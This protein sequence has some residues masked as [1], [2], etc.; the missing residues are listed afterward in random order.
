M[1]AVRYKDGIGECRRHAPRGPAQLAW[2]METPEKS[3]STHI[4]TL[5][6]FPPVPHDDWCGEWQTNHR[7]DT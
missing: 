2:T 3:A 7:R 4:V 1:S 5:T 6:P